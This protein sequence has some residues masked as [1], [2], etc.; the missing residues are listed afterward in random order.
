MMADGGSPPSAVGL[1]AHPV[2]W[3]RA[4]RFCNA[5][6]GLAGTSAPTYGSL[7]EI[8]WT[9][10]NGVPGPQPLAGKLPHGFGVFARLGKV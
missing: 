7:A 4:G 8:A 1:P 10:L 6:S 9:A 3:F 5:A 2:T